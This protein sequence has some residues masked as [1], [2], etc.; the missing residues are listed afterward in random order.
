MSH[1]F[2]KHELK[3]AQHRL[4]EGIK[5]YIGD[6]WDIKSDGKYEGCTWDCTSPLLFDMGVWRLCQRAVHKGALRAYGRV[7]IVNAKE[8]IRFTLLFDKGLII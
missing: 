8:V 5:N 2:N 6:I 7:E 1:T 3:E 4:I